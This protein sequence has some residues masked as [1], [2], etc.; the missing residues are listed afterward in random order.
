[1][2]T[3]LNNL[4]NR[5]NILKSKLLHNRLKYNNY[6]FNSFKKEMS[7]I[8]NEYHKHKSIFKA[9]SVLGL[10]QNMVLKWYIQ[11]QRGNLQFRSFYLRINHINNLKNTV[12]E[13][14]VF[15]EEICE[16]HKISRYGDGWSYTTYVDGEKVCLISDDLENLKNKVK[17]QNL[18][19]N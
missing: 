15:N 2:E 19:L 3:V 13:P 16:D 14:V 17:S 11:G 10:N 5:N 4:E 1:M 8:L 18:P 6:S 7:Q 12:E 9:A